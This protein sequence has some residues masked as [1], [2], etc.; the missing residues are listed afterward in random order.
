MFGEKEARMKA[1]E[2]ELRKTE[3]WGCSSLTELDLSGFATGKV[4]DMSYMFA[5][6]GIT[7]E[8]AGLRME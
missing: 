7:A 3:F 1:V 5:D 2:K 4:T 6:C 8:E